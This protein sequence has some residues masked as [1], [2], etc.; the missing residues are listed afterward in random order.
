MIAPLALTMGD[1]AGIGA[2]LTVKAWRLLRKKSS[3]FFW[4]GDPAL[5]EASAPLHYISHPQEALEHFEKSIPVLPLKCPVSV[6]PGCPDSRNAPAIM[7]S[8]ERAVRE[9][10]AGRAS[11]VVT[12][13]IAKY[14]LAEAG[15]S[16]PGHTEFLASLCHAQGQE[17]MMLACPQLKV[18]L[19]SIHIS[20][21]QAIESLTTERIVAVAH[22]TVRALRRDFGLSQPRLAIAGLNPHAGENGLMGHEDISIVRP[23]VQQLQQEGIVAKGPLPSDTMF[24]AAVR[25]QYDVAVCLYHDQG[26]IPV[27]TLDMAG[28]VNVTLGLPIIRTSPDHGT[29]FDIAT[30]VE[31]GHADP[32]SLISALSLAKSMAQHRRKAEEKG[33]E[34]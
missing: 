8:I 1:P 6:T 18:V 10:L 28:G 23:A 19:S 12:N 31:Q 16:F 11:G 25:S 34:V 17:V 20:L 21:R 26:L 22:T 2:E 15:F 4:I 7:E 9:A 29:A 3:P 5:L 13:P 24:S 33:E 27:K 32:A 30:S 14:V